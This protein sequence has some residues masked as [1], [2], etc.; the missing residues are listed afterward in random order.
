MSKIIVILIKRKS[1]G[2]ILI[3]LEEGIFLPNVNRGG[4][5][6]LL[7]IQEAVKLV[8]IQASIKGY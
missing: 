2:D 6:E 5:N 4:N 1:I 8:N 3:A 7:I